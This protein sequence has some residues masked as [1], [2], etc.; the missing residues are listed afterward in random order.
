MRWPCRRPGWQGDGMTSRVS[1]TTI[2]CRNAFELS[3][4]WKA[5][6]DYVDVEGDPNLPGHDECMILSRDGSHRLLFIEVPEDRSVKNRIHF[7]LEPV[8]GTRDDELARLLAHGA[9]EVADLRG[10]W[11]PGSGW[12][13]LADPEG[14]EFCILRSAVE[15]EAAP[16]PAARE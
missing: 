6:L 8:E 14:N 1:H 5:V 10:R 9:V 7:D 13:V 2:D 11:G 12:V 3:Q 16:P 4:W 15:R